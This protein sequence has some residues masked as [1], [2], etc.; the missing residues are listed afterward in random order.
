MFLGTSL[1]SFV[2]NEV[3]KSV[4]EFKQLAATV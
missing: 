3:H 2:K 1:D 4:S